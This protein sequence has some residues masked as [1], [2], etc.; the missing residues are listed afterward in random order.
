MRGQGTWN[1]KNNDSMSRREEEKEWKEAEKSGEKNCKRE[2][3]DEGER[4]MG[5]RRERRESGVR[6]RS[7]WG[8]GGSVRLFNNARIILLM[9]VVK[10]HDTMG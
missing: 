6:E 2:G 4:E 3:N 10:K 1:G 5:N 9:G 7:V 8:E